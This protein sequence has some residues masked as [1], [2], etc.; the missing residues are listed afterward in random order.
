MPEEIV[1][2]AIA[3]LPGLFT[4]VGASLANAGE[5]SVHYGDR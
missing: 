2:R 3:V 5:L 4:P 1:K